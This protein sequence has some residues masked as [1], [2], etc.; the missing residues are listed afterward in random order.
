[1]KRAILF[2][3]GRDST[4]L[5]SVLRDLHKEVPV[6]FVDTGATFPHVLQHVK[7]MCSYFE[8]ALCIIKPEMDINQYHKE[9]GLPVDLFPPENHI[10][11]RQHLHIEQDHLLTSWFQCC[12][13]N[14]WLPLDRYLKENGFERVYL[15][16]RK[17]EYRKGHPEPFYVDDQG[18][19]R[20]CPLWNWTEEMILHHLKE[21]GISLPEQYAYGC[22]S[23]DCWLCTACLDQH[24]LK[25]L[26]YMKEKHPEKYIE[27]VRRLRHVKDVVQP[28]MDRLNQVV[29]E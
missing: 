9:N 16:T 18:L 6:L 22:D 15:G 7:W 20:L 4:C 5:L 25:K 24:G 23:L 11:A 2:S 10:L 27:V 21:Q 28:H 13:D 17:E 8:F 29:G 19:E 26:A 3:G 14:M 1:M 12:T